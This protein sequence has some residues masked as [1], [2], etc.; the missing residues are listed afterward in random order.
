MFLFA[1]LDPEDILKEAY[2]GEL[3]ALPERRKKIHAALQFSQARSDQTR[4]E[5][6]KI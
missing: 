2:V 4:I 5:R 3:T 1:C 6:L